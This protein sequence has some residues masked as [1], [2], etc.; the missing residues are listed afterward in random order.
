MYLPLLQYPSPEATV[1][2]RTGPNTRSLLGTVRARVQELEP[3]LPLTNVWP[4]A[5]VFS[6]A[7]W[8]PKFAAILLGIFALI[9][10]LLCAVGIY[11]VVSYTVG[12]RVREM[13]VRLALGAQPRDV[14]FM[15][16]RQT[17]LTVGIGLGIGL[18]LAF[19]LAVVFSRVLGNLLYGVKA[20]EPVAFLGIAVLLALVGLLA[21]YAPARRAAKVDPV[22]ALR[23]E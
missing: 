11:G 21:S 8:A 5:E 3:N 15:V 9:A 14:L 1:F 23:Y 13:G 7:L 19:S 18:V 10:M 12:Q 4:I 22:V 20:N 17:G 16:L 6:Q 2:F